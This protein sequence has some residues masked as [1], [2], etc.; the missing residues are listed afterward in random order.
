MERG[1]IIFGLF[2]LTICAAAAIVF[3]VASCSCLLLLPLVSASPCC[4]LLLLFLQH[5][6]K[7]IGQLYC[8]SLFVATHL[9]TK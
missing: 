3:A 2:L 6:Q 1:A 4:L 7:S 5:N 9:A 8:I